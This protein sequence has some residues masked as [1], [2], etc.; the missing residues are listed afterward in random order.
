M[1]G[2]ASTG[3]EA[4]GVGVDAS[5][6]VALVAAAMVIAAP[7]PST[8]RRETLCLSAVMDRVSFLAVPF[9]DRALKGQGVLRWALRLRGLWRTAR[10]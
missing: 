8:A 1:R 4:G 6:P 2:P 3:D 5:D 9:R 10:S 7:A